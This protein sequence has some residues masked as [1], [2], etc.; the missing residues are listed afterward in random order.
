MC[1]TRRFIFNIHRIDNASVKIIYYD[2]YKEEYTIKNPQV[3]TLDEFISELNEIKYDIMKIYPLLELKALCNLEYFQ[4]DTTKKINDFLKTEECINTL[5]LKN[6]N[7]SCENLITIMYD[8]QFNVCDLSINM[9]DFHFY[10]I[11]RFL[12][13]YNC[14]MSNIT[15]KEIKIKLTENIMLKLEGCINNKKISKKYI[16]ETN[17]WISYY[18]AKCNLYKIKKN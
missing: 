7:I 16:E 14:I 10:S 5:K 11:N 2:T 8:S 13:E 1:D 6:I 18:K 12:R 4:C 3:F 15:N 17:A 9:H